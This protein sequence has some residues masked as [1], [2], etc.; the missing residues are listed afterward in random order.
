MKVNITSNYNGK[1]GDIALALSVCVMLKASFQKN[2]VY[3]FNDDIIEK[4]SAS[5]KI[6]KTKL[7]KG[8][9]IGK[10]IGIFHK[11]S[12]RYSNGLIISKRLKTDKYIKLSNKVLKNDMDFNEIYSFVIVSPFIHKMQQVNFVSYTAKKINLVLNDQEPDCSLKQTKRL[13][14]LRDKYGMKLDNNEV[15]SVSVRKSAKL[16]NVSITTWFK[17]FNVLNQKG[18]ILYRRRSYVASSKP[19]YNAK[20]TCSYISKG[21]FL[22]QHNQ[23]IKMETNLYSIRICENKFL[24]SSFSKEFSKG[25]TILNTTFSENY[26]HLDYLSSDYNSLLSSFSGESC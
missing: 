24:F 14:H 11:P 23:I 15:Y 17:H 22:N 9:R 7:K 6:S 20:R 3:D 18:F 8:V 19:I 12:G 2:I 1:T 10:E 5:Y 21:C 26:K 16:C 13:I 25:S 4:L